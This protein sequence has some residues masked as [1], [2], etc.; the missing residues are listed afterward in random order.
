MSLARPQ[1]WSPEE[2]WVQSFGRPQLKV[3]AMFKSTSHQFPASRPIPAA[4]AFFELRRPRAAY[5]CSAG[6]ESGER[7][8]AGARQKHEHRPFEIRASEERVRAQW[9]MDLSRMHLKVL[10]VTEAQSGHERGVASAQRSGCCCR[11]FC[12]FCC[13]RRAAAALSCV[14]V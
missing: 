12:C 14:T 6:S 10:P 4:Q 9:T 13:R 11:C 3:V 5:V 2:A 1:R 7:L 8:E